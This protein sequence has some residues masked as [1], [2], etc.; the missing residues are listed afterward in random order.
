MKILFLLSLMLF[1]TQS[2]AQELE[3]SVG[4]KVY[5][6]S[7]YPEGGRVV[8]VDAANEL[9]YLRVRME[10]NREVIVTEKYEDLSVT[11]GC[12][13]DYCVGDEV[14]LKDSSEPLMKVVG[15]NVTSKAV[16]IKGQLADGRHYLFEHPTNELIKK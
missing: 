16:L 3:I 2:F 14:Y 8:Y 5:R 6:G 11:H 1:Q 13:E 10:N 15:V 9:A 12:Y 4:E 7:I